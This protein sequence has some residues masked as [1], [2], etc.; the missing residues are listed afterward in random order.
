MDN[1][2]VLF[3]TAFH[4]GGRG[5]IGAGEAISEQHLE[6]LF[7][8]GKQVHVLALAPAYQEA[9][10][11]VVALCASYTSVVHSRWMTFSALF[12]QL[13]NRSWIGPWFFTRMSPKAL[14]II[15]QLLD[16]YSI[17]SIYL[18]FPSCLGFSSVFNHL[19]LHYIVHDVVTQKVERRPLLRVISQAISCVESSL[20]ER[21]SQCFVLSE[22]DA[23]KCKGMG[24]SGRIDVVMPRNLKI[25]VVSDAAPISDIVKRFAERK[26]LV[27]FGN[28][29]R[30]EN[31]YSILRFL[32]LCYPK[33]WIKHRDVQF[34]ILGL[35]PRKSLR[36]LGLLLPGVKVVG[37]VDD[38]TLAFKESTFCIAPVY[39]GAGVK[40]K[41]LQMLDAGATVVSTPVGAEGIAQ[42]EE[43]VTV[44]NDLL[45]STIINL[46]GNEA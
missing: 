3:I 25:G 24:Y 28:M 35:S 2:N 10:P 9:S 16:Q 20:L 1:N 23:L 22:K 26:N 39:Y 7:A 43:L 6:L 14:H 32:I 31:H 46:L 13:S 29:Q 27:F 42:I 19:P 15:R 40:I 45:T 5:F 21:V 18:D 37:A 34:W 30:A 41:V 17:S 4:P 36:A 38:P 8:Q 44:D 12:N 11:E 33:I